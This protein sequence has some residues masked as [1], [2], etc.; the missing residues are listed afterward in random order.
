M[1][2]FSLYHKL[3]VCIYRILTDRRIT[4]ISVVPPG[5]DQ[6]PDSFK[7]RVEKELDEKYSPLSHADLILQF[8]FLETLKAYTISETSLE[9]IFQSFIQNDKEKSKTASQLK[10]SLRFTNA[11]I[12]L[13]L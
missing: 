11:P 9:Q 5:P 10:K 7:L 13:E 3:L 2:W 1:A 6:A 12:N 8:S 4:E